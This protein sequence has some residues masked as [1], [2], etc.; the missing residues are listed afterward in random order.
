VTLGYQEIQSIASVAANTGLQVLRDDDD[1]GVPRWL[2][3]LRIKGDSVNRV[4]I[5]SDNWGQKNVQSV[6]I[7]NESTNPTGIRW[8]PRWVP[9]TE[10]ANVKVEGERLGV[11]SSDVEVVLGYIYGSLPGIP[12]IDKRVGFFDTIRFSG[13]STLGVNFPAEDNPTDTKKL[14]R[15]FTAQKWSMLDAIYYSTPGTFPTRAKFQY[16]TDQGFGPIIGGVESP[17]FGEQS[18]TPVMPL[19]VLNGNDNLKLL[20]LSDVGAVPVFAMVD[21]LE[22]DGE[23]NELITGQFAT[24]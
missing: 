23:R 7:G 20:A 3:Y 22:L 17:N 10:S 21:L 1:E 13:T 8:L 14:L 11:G 6:P 18:Y 24:P 12:D 2:A 15:E 9:V 19:H 16:P 4:R 5:T